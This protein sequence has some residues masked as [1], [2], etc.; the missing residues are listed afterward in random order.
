MTSLEQLQKE[1]LKEYGRTAYLDQYGNTD[2]LAR[3]VDIEDLNS[4]AEKAYNAGRIAGKK[5]AVDYLLREA[6]YIG[7]G[8]EDRDGDYYIVDMGQF[9]DAKNI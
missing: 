4:F 9:R 7:N 8:P 1:F 2:D 5:E 6:E 3:T